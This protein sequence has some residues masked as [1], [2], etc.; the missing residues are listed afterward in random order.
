MSEIFFF[1][2]YAL[3]EVLAG[4]KNYAKYTQVQG[5]LTVF[6]L[7]E[8][9]YNLKK[10][11]GKKADEVVELYKSFLVDVTIDDIKKATDL[12]VIHKALSL[13]DAVGYV[14]AQRH[15]VKFLTGD[16]GF[17]NFPNVEFVKK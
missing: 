5:I 16:E 1:D 6:N 11:Q 7:A 13:P 3:F 9:S 17:R 2:T 15:N 8:L 12:K 10:E 4:N 14:V